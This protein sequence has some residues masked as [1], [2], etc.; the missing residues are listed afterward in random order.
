MYLVYGLVVWHKLSQMSLLGP[1]NDNQLLK[2]SKAP[3][4]VRL[5]VMNSESMEVVYSTSYK[6]AFYKT[7]FSH[8]SL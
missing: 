8:N 6:K 3:H 1:H 2:D 5:S 4:Y 7:S